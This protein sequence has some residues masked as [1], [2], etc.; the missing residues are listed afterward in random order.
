M[1]PRHRPH[2]QSCLARVAKG[3]TGDRRCDSLPRDQSSNHACDE[4]E[5]L[6]DS[7]PY[8]DGCDQEAGDNEEDWNEQGLAEEFQL[9]L[10]GVTS[11]GGIDPPSAQKRTDKPAV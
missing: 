8:G 3:A 6:E 11:A 9:F 4:P 10:R 5:M 7:L 1:A 2:R